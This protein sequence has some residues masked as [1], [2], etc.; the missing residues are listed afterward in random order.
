M[1]STS[2]SS[3][4]EYSDEDY[5]VHLANALINEHG[6]TVD[7]SIV[8]NLAPEYFELDGG[9]TTE[10]VREIIDESDHINVNRDGAQDR[11]ESVRAHGQPPREIL[12]INP[13]LGGNE[14]TLHALEIVN[15][16]VAEKLNNEGLETVKDIANADPCKIEGISATMTTAKA[17]ALV[18]EAQQHVS[19]ESHLSNSGLSPYVRDDESPAATVQEVSEID[20][21]VGEPLVITQGLDPDDPKAHYHGLLVHQ[22]I[23]HPKVPKKESNARDGEVKLFEDEN[24]DVIEPAIPTEPTLQMP[25]DEIVAKTLSRNETPVMLKGPHGSGKNTV[26]KWLA[27]QTNRPYI[28]IDAHEDMLAQDLFGSMSLDEDRKVVR[29]DTALTAGMKMG[30]LIVINE[31]PAAQAGIL[32]SLHRFLQEGKLLIKET[33][34][35]IEPHSATRILAT[36]NPA[37]VDYGGNSELNMATDDRWATYQH[38]YPPKDEEVR[39]LHEMANRDTQVADRATIRKMVEIAYMTRNERTMPTVSTRHLKISLNRIDD[40]ASPKAAMKWALQSMSRETHNPK[41]LYGEIDD[42]L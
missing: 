8:A 27:Y 31:L 41:D 10:R 39:V 25:I 36:Q 32:M 37:T 23:G 14:A 16:T 6:G 38:N 28:S 30:A 33:G 11:I 29:R 24:G 2:T 42:R 5:V 13:R 22:D 20:T 40:G 19:S 1:S 4:V 21:P 9:T 18:E 12:E 26:I 17:Q 35:L 3:A 15:D 7:A 34:E